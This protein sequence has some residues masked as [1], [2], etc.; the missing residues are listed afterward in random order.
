MKVTQAEANALRSE[1]SFLRRKIGTWKENAIENDARYEE[2]LNQ[3]R[4]EN[5]DLRRELEVSQQAKEALIGER[6]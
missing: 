2:S 5:A 1:V 6:D 3:L 4:L